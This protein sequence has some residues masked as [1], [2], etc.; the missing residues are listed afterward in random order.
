MIGRRQLLLFGITLFTCASILCAAAPMLWHLIGAR[1]VQGL[2]A[3]IMM[4]LTMAFVGGTVPKERTGRAMGL[5]GTM[6]ALGTALGPS[7]GG[8]LISVFGWQAIFVVHVPLGIVTLLLAYRFL[9]ADQPKTERAGFD[10]LGTIVLA[11]TLAAYALAMTSG[12]GSFGAVNAGLLA[13]AFLGVGLFV[14]AERRAKA[15]LI[16]LAL[17][18]DRV[19]S[20][21]LATSALVATV[22]MA[23]LVVG[24]FYLSRALG[25]DAAL[26][27]LAVSVGP[28]VVALAGVPA[29][30][31]T[32]RFGAQPMILAGLAGMAAGSVLLSGLP[33]TFGIAGYVAPLVVI[34]AGYGLFQTANNTIVMADVAQDRRGTI[35]GM[36]NLSRNLG[37]VTGASAMGAV[38]AVAAGASDVTIAGPE[39]VAAGMRGTFAVAAFLVLSAIAIAVGAALRVPGPRSGTEA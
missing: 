3:A 13:A 9:P 23:T 6:S 33:T 5:L 39:A 26:V 17:F 34:T 18:R 14:I 2:G 20:A 25:L 10:R 19:L 31:M 22:M 36:L 27:G 35:S 12:R 29:G 16:R 8:L 11:A 21:G 28:I 1:A 15:P 7:L 32:D 37:L 4:A 30:R 38:F 24:P